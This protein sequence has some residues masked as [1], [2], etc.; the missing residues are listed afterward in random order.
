MKSHDLLLFVRHKASFLMMVENC[1][2]ASARALQ[3]SE[4]LKQAHFS[5]FVLEIILLTVTTLQCLELR[6][7]NRLV[8]SPSPR[9]WAVGCAW[10][11][12]SL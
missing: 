3:G 6:S 1:S 7:S 11:P 2:P 8:A 4:A 9:R 10:E 12:R 5:S